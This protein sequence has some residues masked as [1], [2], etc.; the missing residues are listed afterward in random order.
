M[1]K[2]LQ[3]FL[4]FQLVALVWALAMFRLIEIK[5]Q[6]GLMAGGMFVALGLFMV[7]RS[8]R[9][10]GRFRM[11][12][13]YLARIHLWLFALPMVLVR[14]RFLGHD[15]ADLHFLGISGPIYHRISEMAF[16]IMVA[17]TLVDWLRVRA[18]EN[19]KALG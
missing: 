17:A 2:D 12:S 7:L 5:W 11:A 4:V 19:K 1:K 9:W 15:F 14:L 6:A 10:I 13:F 3:R 8:L 18:A 16:L